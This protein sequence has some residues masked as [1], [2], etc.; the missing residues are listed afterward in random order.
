MK[1][2]TTLLIIAA[3]LLNIITNAA[4][5]ITTNRLGNP[6]C[7]GQSVNVFFTVVG[8][9]NSGNVFTAQLSDITGGFDS[10]VNIGSLEGTTSS[11]IHSI[12]P[13]GTA[14]GTGYR[15]RVVSTMPPVIGTDNGTD[16][17]VKR[18][19]LIVTGTI[20]AS[21]LCQGVTVN[22]P[23]T[24]D[25][26]FNFGNVFTAEL[27]DYRGVFNNPISIGTLAGTSNGIIAATIPS[28]I[29]PGTAYL[30]R[31]VSNDPPTTG[32]TSNKL[33]INECAEW[34]GIINNSWFEAGNWSTHSVPSSTIDVFIRDV[35]PQPSPVVDNSGAM[36]EV[37]NLTISPNAHLTLG[38]NGA[39]L[40]LPGNLTV[41]GSIDGNGILEIN[42]SATITGQLTFGGTIYVKS[43]GKLISNN[44][45]TLLSGAS[46][47][48]GS[49]TPGAGGLVLGEVTVQRTGHYSP[50][51]YTYWSS[52]VKN[53]A[54]NLLGG[55]VFYYNPDNAYDQSL[56]GL[57]AGWVQADGN[58]FKGIGYVSQGAGTVSFTGLP[59]EGDVKV[60]V[61]KNAAT[62]VG[63]NL[64]GNPYA[65]AIDASAFLSINAGIITGSLYFW[66]DDASGGG[67]WTSQDYAVWNQVGTVAGPNSGLRFDGYIASGQSFF[68]EK[69]DP[70]S[71]ILN[72]DNA[73]RSTKNNVFFRMAPI[74]RL[75]LSAVGPSGDYNETLIAFTQEATDGYDYL[76]D[77]RKLYGSTKIA[78][79]SKNANQRF[80]IQALAPLNGQR[81]IT[82]GLDA[83]EDGYYTLQLKTAEAL[84]EN[85]TLILEDMHTG[86][87]HNLRTDGS[88]RF[89]ADAGAHENRFI[90]YITPERR[91]EE[92][93]VYAVNPVQFRQNLMT[94]Y[95]KMTGTTSQE[96]GGAY[97][98]AN[99]EGIHLVFSFGD[100]ASAQLAIYDA[101]GRKLIN[102]SII[103]EGT[104][105]IA[106]DFFR[107]NY[108][109]V[110]VTTQDY[111][112][113]QKLL[114]MSR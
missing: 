35:S 89:Y 87:V 28:Q 31:V 75:W 11:F 56:A 76:Y 7:E 25:G 27:S 10:P 69:V 17:D 79:Y 66:D 93:P 3:L 20:T 1:K 41:L 12:I 57:K 19:N 77:A 60:T 6:L 51:Q 24:V 22:V 30:I 70:G 114:V 42:G 39:P 18:C 98:Y 99:E 36:A 111:V 88:Y 81:A 68:V 103:T 86:D 45:L 91:A 84:D 55:R 97:A 2:Q 49:G 33:N 106:V 85:V 61:T 74:Q 34:T 43:N 101:A 94:M 38:A 23:F 26:T 102:R 37:K 54:A 92:T 32:S 53:A 82:V 21:P 104:H 4:T 100:A 52:P 71:S 40:S 59:L 5:S 64:V 113:T 63:W 105:S 62:G 73:M 107:N 110:Q 48:H 72:F 65:S 78:L 46:L 80:A 83:G 108:V 112:Y 96:G 67:N 95:D 29:T 47:M 16:L 8:N 90:L 14:I 109:I 13:A 15:I 50:S 9:F 44:N 58:M